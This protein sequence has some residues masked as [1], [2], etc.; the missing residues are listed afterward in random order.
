MNG[1][2]GNEA[3]LTAIGRVLL[4]AIFLWAGFGKLMAPGP[5]IGY[6]A[7]VGLPMAPAAYVVALVVELLGGLALLVGFQTRIVAA[8][9]ALF[10]LFTA[11]AVHGFADQGNA[12]N[13]MKN[14]AMTGGFLFVI[15]HG[16]G[17]FSID[18]MRRRSALSH[19]P[20]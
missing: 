17:A 5:T 14:I 7:H 20:A 19:Q 1:S 11:F 12:I 4:A 13:A 10:C 6:F 2:N 15:A 9:L 16:A 3:L 18:A 8:V